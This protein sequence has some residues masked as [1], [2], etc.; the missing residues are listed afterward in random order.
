MFK[1]SLFSKI[2]SG[3]YKFS[4]AGGCC[5]QFSF[6]TVLS[7]L[8]TRCTLV[9]CCTGYLESDFFLA[10]AFCTKMSFT[11]VAVGSVYRTKYVCVLLG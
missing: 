8:F 10:V 4:M 7:W 2:H 5:T 11:L 6:A 3:D 9:A 1:D